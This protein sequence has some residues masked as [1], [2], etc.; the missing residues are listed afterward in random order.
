VIGR[1]L[2]AFLAL[3]NVEANQRRIA[4]QSDVMRPAD[5]RDSIPA[6]SWRSRMDREIE[7]AIETFHAHGAAPSHAG[8][9]MLALVS[10][11]VLAPFS[12]RAPRPS[13]AA[14]ATRAFAIN[15]HQPDRADRRV[16]SSS[17]PACAWCAR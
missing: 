12:T 17:R 1:E 10:H 4:A 9:A 2:K 8:A 13:C 16:V 5:M 6:C 7:A 11:T 3:R 15:A 14:P